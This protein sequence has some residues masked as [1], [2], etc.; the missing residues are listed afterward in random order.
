M[1]SS[2]LVILFTCDLSEENILL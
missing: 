1:L 2:I